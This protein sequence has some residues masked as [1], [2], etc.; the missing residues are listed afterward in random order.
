MYS[1]GFVYNLI[2]QLRW[3]HRVGDIIGYSFAKHRRGQSGVDV[4]CIQVVVLAIE[5]QLGCVA[6]EQVGEC[7]PHHGET[8]H[9]AVLWAGSRQAGINQCLVVRTE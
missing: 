8:E 5:H 7:A 1:C 3:T 9:W 2:S 4:L 6:A